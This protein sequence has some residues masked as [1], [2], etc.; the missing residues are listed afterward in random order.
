MSH[1]ELGDLCGTCGI[2]WGAHIGNLC[3]TGDLA[4]WTDKKEE[5]KL[6]PF[7]LEAAK[8]GEKLVTREGVEVKFGG[9]NHQAKDYHQVVGWV[10]GE[11]KGWN[12]TGHYMDSS[13][14]ASRDLFM[15]SRK[16]VRWGRVVLH[17]GHE[18]CMDTIVLGDTE[19]EVD[20]NVECCRNVRV[21]WEE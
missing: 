18:A 14:G 4:K 9:V 15:A 11:E 17:P 19:G 8:R 20:C 1:H 21:E 7:D 5:M 3:P 2:R 10:G 13:I 16:V 6:K 12:L